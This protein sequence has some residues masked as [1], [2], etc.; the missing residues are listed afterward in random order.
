MRFH[1]ELVYE[2]DAGDVF[3]ML[4]DPGFREEVCEHQQVV[5]Y[6]VNVEDRDDGTHVEVDQTQSLRG[7][8]ESVRMFVG[9]DVDIEQRELWGSPTRAVLDVQ[10]P[11]KPGRMTGTITL[12]QRD[13]QTVETVSGDIRVSVPIVG[14]KVE[15]MVARVFTFALEAER[16]VGERWLAGP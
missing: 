8:A 4:V 9:D 15:E 11:D 10:I 6:S 1:H 2:A 14:R 5:S 7:I 3:A 13:G 16:A 12:A